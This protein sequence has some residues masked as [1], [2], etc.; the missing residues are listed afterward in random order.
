RYSICDTEL[1]QLASGRLD[2]RRKNPEPIRSSDDCDSIHRYEQETSIPANPLKSSAPAEFPG[3][4]GSGRWICSACLANLCATSMSR[5]G[6]YL[7]ARLLGLQRSQLLL[8]I[9]R[10]GRAAA[11]RILLDARLL[12][13]RQRPLC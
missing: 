12:G 2:R 8:G 10:L 13:L 5:G 4:G 9:R 1:R 6:L 7:A 11:N 3:G